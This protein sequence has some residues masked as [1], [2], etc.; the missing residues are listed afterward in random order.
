MQF[1][2]SYD[3]RKVI[4]GLR[5]HFM[6]RPEIRIMVI[7]VNV[8]AIVA[9]VLFYSKRIRPEPFLLG[10]CI[11]LFMMLSFWYLLPST[12]YKRNATFKDRFTIFFLEDKVRL[13]S[14]Q[15]YVDW[16]WQNF[17]GFFESP[18]FF[19]LYF[20]TKLFFLVP[21]DNMGTEFTHELRGIL[22]KRI[23]SMKK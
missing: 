19:H 10:S 17:S 20:S 12:I 14:G 7:L 13:E 3:K 2:F 4:Q 23:A 21:K 5:Y 11:W 9:A 18:H 22:N 8:F 15:G 6:S 1:N 16:N